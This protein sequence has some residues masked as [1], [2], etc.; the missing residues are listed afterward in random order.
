MGWGMVWGQVEGLDD[1][2]EHDFNYLF[3]TQADYCYRC[4]LVKQLGQRQK[5]T[6]H[7]IGLDNLVNEKC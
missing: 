6:K 1:F 7:A 3:S 2:N 4:M 5:F